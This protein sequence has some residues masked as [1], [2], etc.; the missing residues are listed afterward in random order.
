MPLD[1]PTI[2]ADRSLIAHGAIMTLLGLVSGLTPLIA[3]SPAAAL[4]AHSIGVLQGA[5]LFGLAAI[6]PALG[7]S[8]GVVRAAKWCGLIGFY[9]NW[10]GAELA[11]FWSARAMMIVSGVAMPP[12]ASRWMEVAVA[13]LLSMSFLIVAMC[14][15]ILLALRKSPIATKS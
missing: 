2:T 12:G 1:R 9:S 3:R 11:G 7:P 8:R 14:V 13:I 4:Q 6:W 10:V 15:M 5:M